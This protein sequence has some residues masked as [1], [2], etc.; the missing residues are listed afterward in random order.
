LA[1]SLWQSSWKADIM[2]DAFAIMLKTM[3]S[4]RAKAYR[5]QKKL[6]RVQQKKN[7][8][9]RTDSMETQSLNVLYKNFFTS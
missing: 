1:V 8:G 5:P 9:N 3:L 2:L 7:A 4:S 6:V